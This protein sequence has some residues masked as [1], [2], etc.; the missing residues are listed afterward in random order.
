MYSGPSSNHVQIEEKMEENDE[1][2]LEHDSDEELLK[3]TFSFGKKK[4][5]TPE[6]NESVGGRKKPA[7]AKV[8]TRRRILDD[9]DTSPVV[10][11]SG[12]THPF[13]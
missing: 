4:D 6:K 10:L 3:E 2:K 13:P 5:F 1:I 8:D 9:L 12:F 7:V 11:S